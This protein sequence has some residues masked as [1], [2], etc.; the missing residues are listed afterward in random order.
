VAEQVEKKTGLPSL[1]VVVPPI[2]FVLVAVVTFALTLKHSTRAPVIT[3]ALPHSKEA[4]SMKVKANTAA[5]LEEIAN[6]EPSKLLAAGQVDEAIGEANKE[7][8]EKP[9][10]LETIMCVGNVLSEKGDKQKGID[11]LRQTVTAV[12]QSRYVRLN[13]ARHLVLAGKIPEAIKEYEFLCGKNFAKQ[14]LEPRYE[15]ARLYVQQNK[16]AEAATVQKSILDVEPDN[17]TVWREYYYSLARTG[18]AEEGFEGFSK[19][20]ALP[21]EQQPY[22]DA[23]QKI[24]KANNSSS[25]KAVAQLRDDISLRQKQ[26]RPRIALVELLLYLNRAKDA[27]EVAEAAMKT[28]PKNAEI[29]ALLSEINIRLKDDEAAEAEFNHAANLSF[30]RH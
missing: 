6:M 20:V 14:W 11:L 22:A 1:T 5:V 23:S 13:F 27:K 9:D 26:I 7:L 24:L 8:E 4:D 25:R 19:L 10:D 12:P 3:A 18:Q 21:K 30:G 29:R 17:N 2:I 28:D 16:P 15:L